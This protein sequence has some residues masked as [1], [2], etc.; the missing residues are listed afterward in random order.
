MTRAIALWVVAG[1]AACAETGQELPKDSAPSVELPR[2]DAVLSPA[3]TV[4]YQKRRT[5]ND[6]GVELVWQPAAGARVT[7][8][9]EIATVDDGGSVAFLGPVSASESHVLARLDGER[10]QLDVLAATA[11]TPWTMPWPAGTTGLDIEPSA[12]AGALNIVALGAKVDAL[13]KGVVVTGAARRLTVR[14]ELDY[15]TT[16]VTCFANDAYIMEVSGKA[17][18][19]D[20]HDDSVMLHE[21]GHWLE[22]TYGT[23]TNPGGFHDMEPVAPTLAW[24]EGFANWFAQAIAGTGPKYLDRQPK[25]KLYTFDLEHP[26]DAAKGTADGTPAGDLSEALVHGV[27]WDLT[28]AQDTDNDGAAYSVSDVLTVV[29]GLTKRHDLGPGGADFLDFVNDWRCLHPNDDGLL[30]QLLSTASFPLAAIAQTPQ[31]P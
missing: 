2:P 12:M 13:L 5:T 27:L 15:A 10:V 31:C 3:G 1:L 11:A 28:D 25:G 4:R 7:R 18:E 14:W 21:L 8:G 6:G 29:V 20:A 16:C 22:E 17:G 19:E 23:Y 9:A 30:A 26:P 24:S